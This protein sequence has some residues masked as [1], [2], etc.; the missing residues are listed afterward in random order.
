MPSPLKGGPSLIEI[1]PVP[2]VWSAGSA[3]NVVS[4][5]G[6]A[7][8]P[9]GED[10]ADSSVTDG[11]GALWQ[12]HTDGRLYR[13]D[14]DTG[15]A[16]MAGNFGDSIGDDERRTFESITNLY[17]S[18]SLFILRTDRPLTAKTGGTRATP[19]PISNASPTALPRS[20]KS[21]VSAKGMG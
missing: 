6:N 11:G 17:D 12:L 3:D 21:L 1:M 13:I 2:T 20:C 8:P 9:D 14:A 7:T 4:V 10:W 5:S 15:A 16:A 19:L 18:T